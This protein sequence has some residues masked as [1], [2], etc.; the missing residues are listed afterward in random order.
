MTIISLYLFVKRLDITL[1]HSFTAMQDLL[2]VL[3]LIVLSLFLFL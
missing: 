2:N 1:F 3:I